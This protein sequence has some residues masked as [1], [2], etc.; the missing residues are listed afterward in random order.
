MERTLEQDQTEVQPGDFSPLASNPEASLA[1][2]SVTPQGGAS[3][4]SCAASQAA[5]PASSPTP[6]YVIGHIE[7]RFPSLSLEKEAWQVIK[8]EPGTAGDT[9]HQA[10]QKLMADPNNAYIVRQLCW[11]LFVQ[12]I[13][14]YI[15]M[16]RYQTDY[17]LLVSAY[18]SEP[19]PG[20]LELVIGFLG[21]NAS[22]SVCNGLTVPIVAFDNIYPF[23]RESVLESINPKGKT[24]DEKFRAAAAEMFDRI[25]YQSDNSGASPKDRALNY[26]AVRYSRIYE[27][28]AQEFARNASF[29]SIEVRSSPLSGTRRIVDV[30]FSFVSRETDVV[31]KYF[32]RVDVTEEFP[33]LVSPMSP[34]YDR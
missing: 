20:D 22:P 25:I 29:T 8:R 2:G 24:K 11:V 14:T 18:R 13:E 34:F 15:L 12:G 30:I 17:Q 32:V 27:I 28:A 10:M 26:L 31:F 6:V 21:P 19:K 7:P 5:A 9:N 1:A 16:P 33:F 4:P 23:D 3:C